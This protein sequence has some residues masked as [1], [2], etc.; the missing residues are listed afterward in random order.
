LKGTEER[1]ERTRESGVGQK[2]KEREAEKGVRWWKI[3]KEEVLGGR[4][5]EA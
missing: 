2:K 5:D 4:E 3:I 1:V